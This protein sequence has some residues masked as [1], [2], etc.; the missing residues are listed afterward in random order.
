MSLW[1]SLTVLTFLKFWWCCCMHLIADCESRYASATLKITESQTVFLMTCEQHSR[2]K[3][4]SWQ[5]S[6]N[7]SN[8]TLSKEK[9]QCFSHSSLATQNSEREENEDDMIKWL[10]SSYHANLSSDMIFFKKCHIIL[11]KMITDRSFQYH[12][13]VKLQMKFSWSL[14]LHIWYQR[15]LCLIKDILKSEFSWDIKTLHYW[16]L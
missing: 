15:T 13:A 16:A 11:R 10:E 7:I 12:V 4:K 8:M 1:I 9:K 14:L 3:L 6:V 2:C 5:A